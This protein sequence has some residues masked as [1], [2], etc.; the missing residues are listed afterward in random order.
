MVHEVQWDSVT[1]TVHFNIIQSTSNTRKHRD[2]DTC[3]T[4]MFEAKIYWKPTSAH[5]SSPTLWTGSSLLHMETTLCCSAQGQS[6][7]NNYNRSFLELIYETCSEYSWTNYCDYCD[8]RHS[9][10]TRLF[11]S[12]CIRA[13]KVL[14]LFSAIIDFN[15]V[16]SRPESRRRP[17]LM[18]MSA[19]KKR[20][21]T[22]TQVQNI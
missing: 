18:R 15:T 9:A 21:C 2:P 6:V 10:F 16:E 12:Y 5:T 7:K 3:M 11:R 14:V 22:Y 19:I 17:F 1:E 8:Y 20:L 4:F 13:F